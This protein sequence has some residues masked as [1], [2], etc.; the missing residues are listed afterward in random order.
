MVNVLVLQKWLFAF[1]LKKDI[2]IKKLK[3]LYAGESQYEKQNTCR[4]KELRAT[5]KT[6][7]CA[8]K[9]QRTA[10]GAAGRTLPFFI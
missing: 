8:T 9:K 1:I 4:C 3:T 2:I 6:N 10:R 5:I 7:K